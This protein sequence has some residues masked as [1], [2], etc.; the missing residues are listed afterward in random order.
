[1]AASNRKQG[2]DRVSEEARARANA[3]IGATIAGGRY[4]IEELIAQGGIASVFRATRVSDGH[5]M[6]IKVL[7]P[8]AESRPDLTA[9]FEREAIAGKHILHPNVVTVHESSRL[10]DGSWFLVQDF[11][12]GDLIDRGPVPPLQAARIARHVA[13]GLCAAH[14]MGI[15]HRDIKPRNL[16]Y[17]GGSDDLVQIVDFGFAQVPVENLAVHIA[18]D[19]SSRADGDVVFGTM[20]YLAPEAAQGMVAIDRRSDLYALGIILY[21]L[22]AGQPPFTAADPIALFQMQCQVAPPPI[23]E[24]SPGVEVPPALERVVMRLLA[25]D[26]AARYPHARALMVAL[27][28]AIAR[29]TGNRSSGPHL[30][31]PQLPRTT[32]AGI[33]AFVLAVVVLV[34]ALL[35]ARR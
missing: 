2:D 32:L 20:A 4:H 15:V 29:M 31:L 25:K 6:A 16:M 26:P 9:Y 10:E 11:V 35:V 23:R 33:A 28:D 14:D 5:E 24:R 19:R 13:A 21:E 18:H 7:H 34:V 30:L 27:D 22:L 12:R 8:E 1:V 17:V 3:F